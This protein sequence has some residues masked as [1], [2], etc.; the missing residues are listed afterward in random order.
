MIFRIILGLYLTIHFIQLVP[1]AEELFGNEMPYDPKLSPVY[2]IF[3]NV[4]EHV[5]ATYFLIFL[6]AVSILFTCEVYPRISALILYY[7]W[8]ALFN[9][10]LFISNPGLPYLGF[11]LLA[12]TLVESDPKRVLFNTNNR[13]LKYIQ[14]DRLP[15]RIFW[16]AWILMAAGYTFSGLH[17]L[18]VSPSWVDGSAL[19]H[20]LE[21]CLARDN[22]LRDLLLQFPFFLKINTWISLFLE[23]SFLP[24]GVFYYTRPV[25]WGLY[26][27]LHLGILA[28][29]N[30][31]DL[32]IGVLMI[33]L[34]TFE[35]SWS[36]KFNDFMADK[37]QR[38]IN[39]R[40]GTHI[41]VF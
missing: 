21:S 22:F 36:A 15:K 33:H 3:P 29:V 23:I 2:G 1:Y 39:E 28:L 4:L 35:W 30:F 19:Q 24:L 9:R 7:G 32:T 27:G 26:M 5:N 16:S 40:Y 12:M 37:V 38:K 20:V 6:V 18:M 25:Y 13:F 10:N 14:H 41:K 34:M 31:S 8:A 11:I 17:K